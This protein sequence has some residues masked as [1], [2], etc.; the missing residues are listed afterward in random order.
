MSGREK[1][2]GFAAIAMAERGYAWARGLRNRLRAWNA[3]PKPKTVVAT[4]S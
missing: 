1:S 3:L 2:A 4:R